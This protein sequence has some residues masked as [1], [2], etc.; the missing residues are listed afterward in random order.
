MKIAEI[1]KRIPEIKVRKG[2]AF[3]DINYIWAD[4][5]K[6]SPNDIFVLP[7][8]QAENYPKFIES[9]K[10]L[11]VH[12]ILVSSSQL[13][14]PGIEGF[15]NIL[16]AEGYVGDVHGKIA[17][18]LSG[19]PSK[20]LKLVGITGT[21]GKT[22][23][24]FIL[25]HIASTLGK[26]CGLIGTVHIRILDKILETGYTTPDSSS[27]N[28]ILKDM[29]DA[30]VEYVFIEMSSHGL[31]LGRTSGLELQGAAFTNLTQDHLDFHSTMEDY[32]DSKFKL[33]QILESSSLTNKF[34]IVASDVPGGDLMI[35]KLIA[36]ELKSPI[37]LMGNS[38]EFNYSHTKLSLTGSEFRLHRKEKDVP[39]IEVRKVKTNLLGNFNIFNVS[40][41]AFISFE[42]GLPWENILHSIESIPTVPG[43]FQVIPSSDNSRIAVIDYAHTPDALENI[44][45]SCKEILPKQLICLFGCGGDRDRT[46]RPMMARIAEE[47]S[48]FVILTSDNPRTEDPKSILGEV[49]SGF[50]R[51]FRRYETVVD[52]RSAIEQGISML[53]KDG[54]LVVA[55]KGHETYQII[56][57]TKTDFNDYEEV[58]KAFQNWEKDR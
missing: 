10:N 8:G 35:T 18:L 20:K 9:A 26:K 58:K 12:S 47:Y 42:L 1:I 6:L 54:I 23:L 30:G 52:R 55:G 17:S 51:G 21:N 22:S 49:E 45:K 28:L 4:T 14:I 3:L 34:G 19:N 29:V 56:G 36:A 7:E 5:R 38:G 16:E 15:T 41:A 25:F 44:L 37:Y 48:D 40:L 32:L 57:K 50:S 24:T 13:K 27:L 46:K 43:R 33:F 39:F 11:G 31:K 53:E 2:D